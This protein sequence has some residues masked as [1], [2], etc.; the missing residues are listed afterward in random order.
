MTSVVVVD[1]QGMV[2]AGFRSLLEGEAGVDVVGEAADGEQAIEV[3]SR[4]RPDVSG[5]DLVAPGLETHRVRPPHR[6]GDVQELVQRPAALG[7]RRRK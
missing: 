1:D 5:R 2:R 6:G 4:L 7:E 3:V